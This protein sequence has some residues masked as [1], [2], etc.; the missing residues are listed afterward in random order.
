[1]LTALP[2]NDAVALMIAASAAA[3][4]PGSDLSGNDFGETSG[5]R[6]TWARRCQPWPMTT[7]TLTDDDQRRCRSGS[8]D[9]TRA[10]G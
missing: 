4:G 9:R 7:P 6:P 2:R 5:G 10:R 1:M 3:M 8:G